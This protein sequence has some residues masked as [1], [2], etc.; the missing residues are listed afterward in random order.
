MLAKSLVSREET[1]LS[2]CLTWLC[3]PVCL[4]HGQ[5]TNHERYLSENKYHRSHLEK[6]EK[7][8]GKEGGLLSYPLLH[9]LS[10]VN[11]E[12]AG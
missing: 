6:N 7:L 5:A 8:L 2:V 11:Q 9:D 4:C 1:R 12:E 10:H 3:V